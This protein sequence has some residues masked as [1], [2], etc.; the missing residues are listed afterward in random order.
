MSGDNGVYFRGIMFMSVTPDVF[1]AAR[2]ALNEAKYALLTLV[3]ALGAA[4]AAL[5]IVG[6]T[7]DEIQAA[8]DA[9]DAAADVY[10]NVDS[11]YNANTSLTFTSFINIR[12]ALTGTGDALEAVRIALNDAGDILTSCGNDASLGAAEAAYFASGAGAPN[13][14][15]ALAT[16]DATYAARNAANAAIVYD[17]S[18]ITSRIYRNPLISVQSIW[19]SGFG[20]YELSLPSEYNTSL[21]LNGNNPIILTIRELFKYVDLN[22]NDNITI[23]LERSKINPIANTSPQVTFLNKQVNNK[24]ERHYLKIKYGAS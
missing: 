11:V 8:Q 21:I 10:G 12:D 22:T 24:V 14:N 6:A 17:T 2:D 3:S 15:S 13:P 19:K 7:F 9:R 20:V 18:T 4:W 5:L 23:D 16:R 1:N